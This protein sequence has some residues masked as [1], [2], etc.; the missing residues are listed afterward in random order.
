MRKDVALIYTITLLLLFTLG[1]EAKIKTSWVEYKSGKEIVRAYMAQPEGEGP[2]PGLIVIHEWWGLNDWVKEKA[3]DFA[4]QGYVALAVDLYRGRSAASSDE[5]HELMRGVPEDRAARDLK[6]ADAFLKTLK[7]VKQDRIGS[8]GWCMGGGYSLATALNVKSLAA[9]VICYGRMVTEQDEL[10]K[11]PCPILG[12][13]GED[14]RGIPPTS[15]KEFEEA[16]TGEGKEVR[17]VIY[18]DAGHGFMNPNNKGGYRDSAATDA[19]KQ[20]LSFFESTLKKE[21][22]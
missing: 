20:I 18:P 22:K 1:A 7:N 12:I 2:F 8:I 6:A 16:A 11:I 4:N 19:W 17:T 5:A 14:D 15:V 3:D 9:C 13:F 10:Q 21:N